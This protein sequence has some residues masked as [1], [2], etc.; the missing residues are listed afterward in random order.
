MKRRISIIMCIISIL[1]IFQIITRTNK[2]N[3]EVVSGTVEG[4]TWII[5]TDAGT[6]V[7]SGTGKMLDEISDGIK[8][9]EAKA[10]K[11]VKIDTGITGIENDVFEKFDNITT[12]EI[13]ATVT[14]FD[15][16]IF[17]GCN[18][19][20]TTKWGDITITYNPENE[21]VIISGTGKFESSIESF[22]PTNEFNLKSIR[23]EQGITSIGNGAFS[24]CKGLTSITIPNSVTSIGEQA[25][26]SCENLESVELPD[27]IKNIG[28]EAFYKC[29]K[30]KSVVLPQN[31]SEIET[32]VFGYCESLQEIK[33]H[34]NIKEIGITAFEGCEL[35]EKVEIENSQ[36]NISYTSFSGCEKINQVKV[37]TSELK[38]DRETDA[39]TIIGNGKDFDIDITDWYIVSSDVKSIKIERGI[40]SIGYLDF[41]NYTGL[42]DLEIC[43]GVT[44]IE[45]NLYSPSGAF[46]GCTSLINVKLPSSL[47]EIGENA[48]KDCTSL[49]NIEIP[50]NL[51]EIHD[52]A[53]EGCENLV[54]RCKKDSYLQEYAEN[55]DIEYEIIYDSGIQKLFSNKIFIIAIIICVV[56]I[57]AVIILIVIL[58][59]RKKKKQE[60]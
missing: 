39:I 42:T 20:T 33:I 52:S 45:G 34:K 49:T 17:F 47:E 46:S 12:V 14:E 32:S 31:L 27:S 3:A 22:I 11:T 24:Y 23:I 25:F 30:L 5:D 50:E 2:V 56:V 8:K 26:S 16:F 6:A 21:S 18:N 43:E 38:I 60:N 1:F 54:L 28:R 13:S 9:D 37:G 7:F 55:N 35:L 48:F 15:G 19:L 58:K 29:V 57:L 36:T 59:I 53:F 51:E 10:V 40:E 41:T 4:V 44:K